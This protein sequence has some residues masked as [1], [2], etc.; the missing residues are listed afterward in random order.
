MNFLC[1]NNK[2]YRII[3]GVFMLNAGDAAYLRQTLSFFEML[4]SGEQDYLLAH[5]SAVRNHAGQR[6]AMIL[7]NNR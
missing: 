4:S 5:A 3:T 7:I 1:Y 2:E 6:S